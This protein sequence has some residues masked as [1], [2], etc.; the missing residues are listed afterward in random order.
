MLMLVLIP[1]AIPFRAMPRGDQTTARTDR[2]R[3]L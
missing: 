3:A 1:L 2:R